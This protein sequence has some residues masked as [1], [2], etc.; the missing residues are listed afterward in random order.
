MRNALG[1]SLK[2]SS[3]DKKRFWVLGEFLELGASKNGK[4]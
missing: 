3:E 1:M 2:M 4:T